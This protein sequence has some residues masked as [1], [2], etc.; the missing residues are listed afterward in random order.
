MI[1]TCAAL[2]VL[3][4]AACTP[5]LTG[6]EAAVNA[7]YKP[8][9]DTK[10]DTGTDAADL[11]LTMDLALKIQELETRAEERVF[12][13]DV[14][15]NCQDCTD[16]ANL[17]VTTPTDPSLAP[18]DGHSFVEATL[19]L[20]GNEQKSVFWDL[21][22]VD[23]VWQVD[24]IFTEGFDLRLIVDDMLANQAAVDEEPQAGIMQCMVMLRLHADALERA[25]P[26]GDPAAYDAALAG[27]RALAELAMTPDEL[28]QFFASSIAVLDD[29]PADQIATQAD[30][31]LAGAPVPAPAQ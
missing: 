15:G 7:I 19:T 25:T 23:G 9:V 30:A 20:F 29:T 31:C 11:P 18:R 24:N 22:Q 8:L 21:M 2:A 27:Y 3:V 12:D 14:A 28:A 6:P 17:K 1:R 10:G 26:P 16:F 4:L 13:F 5:Q